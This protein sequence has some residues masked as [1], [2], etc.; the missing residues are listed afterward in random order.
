MRLEQLDRVARGVLD[1]H[2]VAADTLNDLAAKADTGGA[3]PLDL[4]LQ[5]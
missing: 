2:L 3:Q 4:A 5:V 1:Q